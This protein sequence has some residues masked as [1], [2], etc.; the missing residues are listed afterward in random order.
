MLEL[1]N[2]EFFRESEQ[3]KHDYNMIRMA[4]EKFKRNIGIIA[5][6]Q[7]EAELV[8]LKASIRSKQSSLLSDAIA[9]WESNNGKI[10]LF[11]LDMTGNNERTLSRALPILPM[12]GPAAAGG[13]NNMDVI[14]VNM[15]GMGE[16]NIENNAYSGIYGT[17]I[18]TDLAA[19]LEGACMMYKLRYGVGDKLFDNHI[20]LENLTRIYTYMF[21]TTIKSATQQPLGGGKELEEDEANFHV[22]KFF[23]KYC[24][25]KSNDEVIDTAAYTAIRAR[26]P[27][28]SILD[29]AAYRNIDY[30]SLSGFLKTLG[31]EFFR[32]EIDIRVFANRWMKLFGS[33]LFYAI[34]YVPYLLFF[35]FAAMR[36]SNLGNSSKITSV[37]RAQLEK[38]GLVRLILEITAELR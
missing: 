25:G 27:L 23:I 35:L 22:A 21:V 26:T 31:S 5:P 37:Q 38:R 30:T 11:N 8:A 12:K 9:L 6:N 14:Y 15:Y 17:T 4:Q 36:N 13:N 34:E 16:W 18:N 24:L 28:N 10:R 7:M 2:T 3:G 33:G 29:M 20:I 19:C 1:M 32:E